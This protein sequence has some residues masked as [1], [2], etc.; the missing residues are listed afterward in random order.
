M[1]TITKVIY[2]PPAT[3][4][5]WNDG[6]KTMAKCDNEDT[7]SKEV[8]FM[9]CVMKKK[10]GN[11][12]VKRMFERYVY[13]TPTANY[14]GATV[15]EEKPCFRKPN[16]TKHKIKVKRPTFYLSWVDEDWNEWDDAVLKW[17]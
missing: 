14:K 16:V 2:N 11:K 7:Y 12:T 15:V 6:T 4:I 17:L 3:I 10:Y 1:L 9:L 5:I 13:N 8:G